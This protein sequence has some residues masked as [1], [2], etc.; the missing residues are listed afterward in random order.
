MTAEQLNALIN[1]IAEEVLYRLNSMEPSDEEVTGSVAIVTTYVPS[2]KTAL[3]TLESRH[4][5]VEYIVHET[6][7]TAVGRTTLRVQEENKH[8]ILERVASSANVVLVTPK[9][10]LLSSIASGEDDGYVEHVVM[11]SLLWGRNVE[12]LLDFEPPKYKRNTFFEKIVTILTTLE[13][14]GMKVLTYKCSTPDN[15]QRY[16]LVTETEVLEA[17]KSGKTQVMCAP[18][19]IVT[20]SAKDKAKEL[21]IEINY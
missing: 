18:G 21:E 11:R 6:E 4:G 10:G 14:M 9:L 20:P 17:Y 8:E 5:D 12:V 7:F 13:D 16:T 3:E 1:K 15:E 2:M 19:A